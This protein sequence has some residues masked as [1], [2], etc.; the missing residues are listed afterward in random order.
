MEL[1][2]AEKAIRDGS[3]IGFFVAGLTGF[4]VV[5]A[6]LGVGGG[7]LDYWNDPFLLFDVAIAA[8][9]AFGLRFHSRVCAVLLFLH[10]LLAKVMM[11][12][13]SG[14][15]YGVGMALIILVF[16]GRAVWGT[17]IWH[18][19]QAGRA[20]THKLPVN[21][22]N[23]MLVSLV[24]VGLAIG[25][26]S[27]ISTMGPS[28]HVVA[29][30]DISQDDLQLLIESGIVDPQENI[31]LFCSGG[32]LSLIEEGTVMTD[33]R[34]ISYEMI[35]G[36]ILVASASFEK[37][38][39]VSIMPRPDDLRDMRLKITRHDGTE[40]FVNLSSKNEGYERFF[41]ELAN[42]VG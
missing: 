41:R 23:V 10:F 34:I 28:N 37:I 35:D 9:L 25:A 38:H 32:L 24:L 21:W 29:G 31:L 16:L 2:K 7:A 15:V 33:Q 30:E 12:L 26:L 11:F 4:V 27:V 42:R 17:F 13:D 20:G 18:R 5:I 36:R 6:S 22:R 40:F 39:H 19:L 3:N 8:G 14:K 1:K